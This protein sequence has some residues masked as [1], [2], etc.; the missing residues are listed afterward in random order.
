MH[1]ACCFFDTYV[2]CKNQ[3]FLLIWKPLI[4]IYTRYASLHHFKLNRS[5]YY[6]QLASIRTQSI[7]GIPTPAISNHHDSMQ[8]CQ[9][10]LLHLTVLLQCLKIMTCVHWPVMSYQYDFEAC[11]GAKPLDHLNIER[12][13]IYSLLWRHWEPKV[14]ESSKKFKNVQKS[15]VYRVK[16]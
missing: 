15:S 10:Q 5:F 2:Y 13:K 9:P 1:S 11:Y 7:V 8:I 12:R 14:Q 16:K 4:Y 3:T 6:L